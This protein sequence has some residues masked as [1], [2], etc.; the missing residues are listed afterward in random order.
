MNE[1]DAIVRNLAVIEST[2][3]QVFGD[4]L[5]E[6]AKVDAKRIAI[7][8]FIVNEEFLAKDPSLA[9]VRFIRETWERTNHNF[10]FFLRALRAR[11]AQIQTIESE[12]S[13]RISAELKR[14]EKEFKF[15]NEDNFN[16]YFNGLIDLYINLI[17][18]PEKNYIVGFIK[19]PPHRAE[20]QNAIDNIK[21]GKVAKS[22]RGIVIALTNEE[23]DYLTKYLNEVISWN[24]KEVIT[25]D[26]QFF[27][28]KINSFLY[29]GGDQYFGLFTYFKDEKLEQT[30][31]LNPAYLQLIKYNL[32]LLYLRRLRDKISTYR[33]GD[34]KQFEEVYNNI[35]KIANIFTREFGNTEIAS[36][37]FAE[38]KEV[39]EYPERWL[40]DIDNKIAQISS[41]QYRKTKVII[42]FIKEMEKNFN[43]R[44]GELRGMTK[45]E[46]AHLKD[47]LK[48]L[49]KLERNTAENVMKEINGF[50]KGL[51]KISEKLR[52]DF[53]E[54]SNRCIDA[55]QKFTEEKVRLIHGEIIPEILESLKKAMT[56][57]KDEGQFIQ[58]IL[59][60]MGNSL[61]SD[62]TN[63]EDGIKLLFVLNKAHRATIGI[64]HNLLSIGS[65]FTRKDILRKINQLN[66][67][68]ENVEKAYQELDNFIL[69]KLGLFA[70]PTAEQVKR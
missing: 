30:L 17:T 18:Y 62:A 37:L 35:K 14:T 39:R 15:D 6:I 46:I 67:D 47:A 58:H 9:L 44:I 31:K 68:F 5:S 70:K 25:E 13:T 53:D 16:K 48:P 26:I 29:G 19:T 50:K 28:A 55:L 38:K 7:S 21:N 12:L 11:S 66:K 24:D 22:I 2:F 40:S 34:W 4:R 60:T 59:Q 42:P 33:S 49:I 52:K 20:L 41:V 8:K 54:M 10:L 61:E 57:T 56:L 43:L 1:K 32:Q 36:E 64:N 45:P 69:T 51:K 65:F 27:T 63:P 23:I 3:T